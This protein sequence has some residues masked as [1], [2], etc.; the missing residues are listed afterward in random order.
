MDSVL[1][2]A[3]IYVFLLVIFRIAGRRTLSEMTS[4]D[5]VLL[6]IVSE[7]TQQ[8]LLGNDFSLTN[9][10]LVILTL[11]GL[12]VTLSLWKQRSPRV[13]KLLDGVPM[14]IVEDGR[15]LK[16]RMDKARIDEEDILTAARELQGLARMD[17][18]QYAVL[19]R[20]GGISVIPKQG[21][22]G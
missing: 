16:D 13:E 6:L 8:G 3:A 14:V 17:Q 22:R 21:S 4:F 9:A 12:D 2:S 20:S 10:F 7:A 5:F 1:R 11:I 15:P 19:E 18:I